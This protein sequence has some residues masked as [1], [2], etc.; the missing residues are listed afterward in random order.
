MELEGEAQ[1]PRAIAAEC[2]NVANTLLGNEPRLTIFL[3]GSRAAGRGSSR[4]DVDIGID[5][6]H[7]IAPEVMVEL[8]ERFEAL[9]VLQRVDLVDFSRVDAGFRE[10]ALD[11]VIVLHERDAA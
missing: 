8:R 10:I 11:H 7:P 4:S 3:F 9:P 2:E 6:G 1:V 5:V